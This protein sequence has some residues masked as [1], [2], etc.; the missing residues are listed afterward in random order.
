MAVAE[1][2]VQGLALVVRGQ[3]LGAQER[4]LAGLVPAQELPAQA[5]P[6]QALAEVQQRAVATPD[7]SPRYLPRMRQQ[8]ATIR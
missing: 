7:L 6:A 5:L 1:R 4:V 8:Q 3:E 2:V